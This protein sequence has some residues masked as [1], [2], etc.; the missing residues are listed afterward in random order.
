MNTAAVRV[1][2]VAF[3]PGRE[4][5]SFA[6][7]LRE[8]TAGE[9]T[10]VIVDNGSEHDVVDDVARRFDAQVVRPGANLGYGAA[11][12]LGLRDGE[13]P[14]V[15]VSNPDIVWEPHA[16]DALLDAATRHPRA[17]SLGPRILNTD[18]TVYPS[19]RAIPS[20][21]Q[22]AGHALFV[23]L[24][25]GNPWT[26]RYHQRQEQVQ[27]SEHAVGWLSGACLLLRR[28]ALDE[29]G[30]FDETYFMFFEDV[31][32]GERLGR[33]GWHN[34][35]VPTA[36]VVH[37]QGASWRE[38]P[39]AMIRAHHRSAE[40]YLHRRYPGWY[41]LPL[42]AAISVGLRGRAWLETRGSR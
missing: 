29:V 30:G 10:L 11:A 26:R 13:E 3:N 31:D 4:L 14:W 35:F 40:Q 27:L 20:L 23:R 5:E 42:R 24:W 7:S 17:G 1:V 19:A 25:P 12:N 21:T 41:R 18:G 15:V 34:V 9:V 32:L 28:A 33:T 36:R 8:A 22:G 38:R 2:T 16:L 39:A 6:S 37:D